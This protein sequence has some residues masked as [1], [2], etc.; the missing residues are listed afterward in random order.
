MSNTETIG[1]QNSKSRIGALVTILA[2]IV[3]VIS[4]SSTIYF[5]VKNQEL[6]N[7]LYNYEPF[8]FAN[9]SG[10]SNLKT[11]IY[12]PSSGNEAILYGNVAIDL[13]IITPY[14]GMVT[15]VV[16]SFNFTYL[17]APINPTSNY[18][19]LD[20]LHNVNIYDTSIVPHQYFIRR[21]LTN[22]ISD[23]I[24]VRLIV[25]LK[26][27]VLGKTQGMGFTLGDVV[28]EAN[29]LSVRTNQTITQQF[30]SKVWVNITPTS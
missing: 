24:P 18:L 1:S 2:L 16:K 7:S 17:N 28:L 25:F 5:A 6:Q 20:N 11:G 4:T 10:I 19:D 30:N 29:L 3:G 26:P 14:D 9:Y 12:T 22:S 23:E 27:N 15:I 8:I 13:K 21:D